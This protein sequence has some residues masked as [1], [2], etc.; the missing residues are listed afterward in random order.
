MY[1]T[2]VNCFCWRV[3][4]ES[5]VQFKSLRIMHITFM[6]IQYLLDSKYTHNV[7]CF[8]QHPACRSVVHVGYTDLYSTG[9][10]TPRAVDR[11]AVFDETTRNF[12]WFLQSSR[13]F[14]EKKYLCS[15]FQSDN[16]YTISAALLL[17]V[18]ESTISHFPR[19]CDNL[20]RSTSSGNWAARM[21]LEVSHP[22]RT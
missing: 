5:S 15:C 6:C 14:T 11:F 20:L 19:L 16:P 3:N 1:S 7:S 21:R 9:Q 2:C 13:H 18:I 8:K 22:D 12:S 4:S 17:W 10:M